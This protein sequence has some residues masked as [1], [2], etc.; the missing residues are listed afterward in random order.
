MHDIRNIIEKR[1]KWVLM[2][3]RAFHEKVSSNMKAALLISSLP[4]VGE[5]T[6]RSN[7]EENELEMICA[8]L[9]SMR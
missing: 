3:Q 4:D 6:W 9:P 1:E 2:L 7:D 5:F 8:A